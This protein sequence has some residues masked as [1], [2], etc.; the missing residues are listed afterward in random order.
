[1][2][3]YIQPGTNDHLGKGQLVGSQLVDFITLVRVRHHRDERVEQEDARQNVLDDSARACVAYGSQAQLRGFG[4]G[5]AHAM[6]GS[7]CPNAWGPNA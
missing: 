2:S 4:C 1:M 6:I 3:E 7:A 5:S